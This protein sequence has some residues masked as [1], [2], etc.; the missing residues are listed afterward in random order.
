MSII[1]KLKLNKYSN[2]VVINEPRIISVK[3]VFVKE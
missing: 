1:D 2:M 3:L